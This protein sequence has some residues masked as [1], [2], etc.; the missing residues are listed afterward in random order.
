M[1]IWA[2]E[3][4]LGQGEGGTWGGS[5]V[6]EGG[7]I[8]AAS[9]CPPVHLPCLSVSQLPWIIN[10]ECSWTQLALFLHHSYSLPTCIRTRLI[11]TYYLHTRRLYA[12]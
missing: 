8:C 12:A 3:E 2:K 5:I 4:I 1:D 9:I 7:C 10:S 11:S 6:L